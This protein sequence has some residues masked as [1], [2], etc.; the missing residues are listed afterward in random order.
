MTIQS[1]VYNWYRQGTVAVTNGSTA[2]T[3]TTTAFVT[4]VR[5]GDGFTADGGSTWYEIA[6]VTDNTHLVLVST[7][8]GSTASGLSYA[9]DRRSLAWQVG[10]EVSARLLALMQ[11]LQTTLKT[12]GQPP[13]T[14][15]SDGAVAF[16]TAA[17]VFYTNTGGVWDSGTSFAGIGGPESSTA[18]HLALFAD[19]TGTVLKDGGTVMTVAPGTITGTYRYGFNTTPGSEFVLIRNTNDQDAFFQLQS[20]IDGGTDRR[21]YFSWLD[22]DAAIRWHFGKNP[23]HSIILFDYQT[24]THRMQLNTHAS[25]GTPTDGATY[26]NSGGTGT[27]EIN[28]F[29]EAGTGT[30]GMR[31]WSGGATPSTLFR[32]TS[33]GTIAGGGSI[34]G[35]A[36]LQA[37]STTKG[38]LPPRMTTAQRA[39]IGS[40]VD[41][42][43]VYDTDLKALVTR[44]NSAWI[45]AS[46]KRYFCRVTLGGTHQSGFTSSTYTKVNFTT[47]VTDAD[48]AFSTGTYQY[49]AAETGFYYVRFSVGSYNGY[50]LNA[51]I[52]VNGAN[53]LAGSQSP[54]GAV[55]PAIVDGIVYLVAGDY[56]EPY[57]YQDSG[58][59]DQVYGNTAWTNFSAMRV[60]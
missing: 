46:G 10:S 42:L 23:G 58:S 33:G 52:W 18:D 38:F 51:Y 44:S 55:G 50:R 8:A 1:T 19:T 36:V 37:D 24:N 32:V 2:V 16:D 11:M 22:T 7:F 14:I 54:A 60:G 48:N 3:G 43:M 57:A 20:G 12:T 28:G 30:G 59:T 5:A 41:G 15:G 27:V 9:I 47:E 31:V 26:I 21:M 39:A 4:N 56:V 34:D 6:S 53:T 45:V 17:R 35:S 40:P 29:G 49:V 25:D 13:D